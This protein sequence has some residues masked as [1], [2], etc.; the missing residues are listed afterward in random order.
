[1]LERVAE[2]FYNPVLFWTA[3]LLLVLFAAGVRRARACWRRHSGSS[4]EADE[5]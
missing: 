5:P 1:M 3:P 2:W 4:S